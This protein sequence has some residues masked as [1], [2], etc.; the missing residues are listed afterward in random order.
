MIAAGVMYAL[1]ALSSLLS[2]VTRYVRWSCEPYTYVRGRR[3]ICR[4]DGIRQEKLESFPP[5][6]QWIE[7][8]EG[9]LL[10]SGGRLHGIVVRDVYAP[11]GQIASVLAEAYVSKGSDAPPGL[12]L[13]RPRRAA[14]LLW[15]KRGEGTLVLMARR[16]LVPAGGDV[17]EAPTAILPPE[18]EGRPLSARDFSVLRETGLPVTEEDFEPLGSILLSPGSVHEWTD[19]Y[20]CRCDEI[21]QHAL[22]AP[23]S[24]LRCE[25][26]EGGG[27][28]DGEAV[29]KEGGEDDEAD[30]GVCGEEDPSSLLLPPIAAFS[31][32]DERVN[33]DATMAVLLRRVGRRTRNLIE[34]RPNFFL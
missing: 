33:S 5:L 34:A 2:A 17:W 3:V 12:V 18:G 23:P 13:L 9:G 1:D 27:A 19:L 25:R 4:G 20:S 30:K 7:S 26:G 14:L 29:T 11:R 22:L 24:P 6:S 32:D 10:R 15:C 21:V 16:T 8:L 28:C 31:V